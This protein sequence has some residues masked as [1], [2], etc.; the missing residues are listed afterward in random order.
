MKQENFI[1]QKEE[2]R[3]TQSQVLTVGILIFDEVEVL[4]FCGPFEVFSVARP[5]EPEKQADEHRLFHVLTIAERDRV[6]ACR[7][8][9]LV[10]PHATI[11]QH[12]L[13]D[14]LVVPGGQ[15]TRRERH[16]E[17]VL[18]WI[19]QQDQ[20]TQL[21]TSVCTGAFLLAERGL[22]NGHQATTHWNSVAWM[23]ETYPTIQ[24]LVD[25]RVVDEGHII[26]SAGISAGIDMSLH[27]VA[28]LCGVDV[29]HWTAR[30]M[31]YDW[32]RAT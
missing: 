17:R 18:D 3:A 23:R 19:V 14:I 13:L 8:G 25:A 10:Q 31:E 4:D 9:L 5:V 16:N 11:E 22:L 21:T 15:G 27:I 20:Y 24:I 6:V 29:A 32:L 30:R 2:V 28:R 12:P 7:G 26:T 1:M